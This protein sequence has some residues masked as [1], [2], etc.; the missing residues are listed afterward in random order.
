MEECEEKYRD[1]TDEVG[2]NNILQLK[3]SA[4]YQF[5]VSSV[6]CFSFFLLS[7]PCPGHVNKPPVTKSLLL[8]F[9]FR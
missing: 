9:I 7:R 3:A 4:P 5:S 6:L 2:E 1:M 8:I